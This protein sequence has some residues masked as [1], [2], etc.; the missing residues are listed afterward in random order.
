VGLKPL[1]QVA[2]HRRANGGSEACPVNPFGRRSITPSMVDERPQ[3]IHIDIEDSHG[4]PI[5]FNDDPNLGF[6][7]FGG[8][9]CS[10]GGLAGLCRLDH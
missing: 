7:A 6:R 3:P 5:H 8:S 1:R 2:G 10:F 4:I 9:F